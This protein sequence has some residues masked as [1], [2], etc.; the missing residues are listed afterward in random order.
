MLRATPPQRISWWRHLWH[1]RH[2]SLRQR[3]H[4]EPKC[5]WL[6]WC[7]RRWQGQAVLPSFGLN[8]KPHLQSQ[9]DVTAESPGTDGT[10][11]Q[12]SSV[13]KP[14]SQCL[15]DGR[16]WS[17]SQGQGCCGYPL[18]ERGS[19]S[20]KSS[21]TS[22]R[23]GSDFSTDDLKLFCSSHCLLIRTKNLGPLVNFLRNF[24][25]LNRSW[26][27][28]SGPNPFAG[29]REEV[30]NDQALPNWPFW[31]GPM[32]QKNLTIDK[33]APTLQKLGMAFQRKLYP[34]VVT[35][36]EALE[37]TKDTW[38]FLL[39]DRLRSGKSKHVSMGCSRGPLTSTWYH[40]IKS[41]TMWNFINSKWEGE[42]VC[43]RSLPRDRCLVVE[44]FPV[45][46]WAN[47]RVPLRTVKVGNAAT[48]WRL[49]GPW[50]DIEKSWTTAYRQSACQ[51]GQTCGHWRLCKQA[52]GD[53][54]DGTWLGA[55]YCPKVWQ[56]SNTHHDLHAWSQDQLHEL[57]HDAAKL[58]G[59]EMEAKGCP[60]GIP[61]CP[62]HR[63]PIA[64]VC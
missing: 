30:V 22:S 26:R 18:P 55:P 49:K 2:P 1:L 16:Q 40:V 31:D 47:H 34:Q 27:T 62:K 44:V 17:S 37:T 54:H 42:Q 64:S 29:D 33:Q 14:S 38:N 32:G 23:A 9:K 57:H 56:A 46:G 20:N 45:W 4:R 53:G 28:R 48:R 50:G 6:Q 12:R 3:G 51:Q 8:G 15:G 19:N 13:L 10:W 61:A 36:E 11:R 52:P 41:F 21:A 39:L 43:Q 25:P 60:L 24:E 7:R 5:Q 35:L 59:S 58:K 63:H